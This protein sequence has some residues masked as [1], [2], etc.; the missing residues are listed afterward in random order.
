MRLKQCRFRHDSYKLSVNKVPFTVSCE[1][2]NAG[3]GTTSGLSIHLYF[4]S[5]KKKPVIDRVFPLTEMTE[6][7]SSTFDQE[8]LV[9]RPFYGKLEINVEGKNFNTL[10][11]VFDNIELK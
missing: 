5:G 8:V 6:G 1:L 3:P 2:E 11:T 9:P 7:T 10:T 4:K